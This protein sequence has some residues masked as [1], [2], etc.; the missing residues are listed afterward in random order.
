MQFSRK[1]KMK[2]IIWKFAISTEDETKA[3]R[4]LVFLNVGS[5]CAL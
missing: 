2:A 1:P 5:C 3:L 4:R